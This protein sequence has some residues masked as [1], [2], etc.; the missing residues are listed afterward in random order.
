VGLGDADAREK[1]ISGPYH[2][3]WPRDFYHAA[4][5]QKAA[6]DTAGAMR[7]LDYLW[8]VQKQDGSCGRTRA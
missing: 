3:V 5:A 7:L 2:L 6:G 4:T 1:E 8:R